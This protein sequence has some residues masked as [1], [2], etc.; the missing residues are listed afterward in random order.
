MK[1]HLI[2]SLRTAVL[3]TTLLVLPAAFAQANDRAAQVLAATGVVRVESVGP[4]VSTGTYRIQVSAKLGRPT[5]TLA[6]GTWLYENFTANGSSAAGTL[7]V[8]FA[9]DRVSSL[10]LA[11]PAAVTALR[12]SPRKVDDKVLIAAWNQR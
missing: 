5:V 12:V 7:V 9:D 8:R 11:S 6:D 4:Y 10:S 3:A 2:S 1:N